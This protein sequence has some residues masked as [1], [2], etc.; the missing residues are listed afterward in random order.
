MAAPARETLAQK[1]SRAGEIEVSIMNALNS[2]TARANIPRVKPI[3]SGRFGFLE[4]TNPLRPRQT[5]ALM[6]DGIDVRFIDSGQGCQKIS[7]GLNPLFSFVLRFEFGVQCNDF[8]F[9]SMAESHRSM[10]RA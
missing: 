1:R 8:I 2:V 9:F 5:S 6:I 4:K 10:I 3:F 7:R